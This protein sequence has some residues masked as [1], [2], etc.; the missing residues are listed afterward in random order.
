MRPKNVVVTLLLSTCHT[1]VISTIISNK[2]T[3]IYKANNNTVETV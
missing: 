2:Y 3:N 1:L